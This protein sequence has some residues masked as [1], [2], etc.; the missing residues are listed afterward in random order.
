M[1][2]FLTGFYCRPAKPEGLRPPVGV[3][4]DQAGGLLVADDAGNAIWRITPLPRL[5]TISSLGRRVKARKCR[6]NINFYLF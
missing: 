3:A 5:Q 4:F 2:P 1:R 6:A